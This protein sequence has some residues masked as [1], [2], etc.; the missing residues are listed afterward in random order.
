[1]PKRKDKTQSPEERLQ[2]MLVPE[3]EQPYPVPENWCWTY[4]GVVGDFFAGSGFKEECQGKQDLPI[5]FYKVGSL[6]SS[7]I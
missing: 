7:D 1:M 3:S 5:P 2:E 6:K 4:W